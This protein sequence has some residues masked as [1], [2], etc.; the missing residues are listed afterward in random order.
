MIS[1]ISTYFNP[2]CLTLD[3][4]YTEWLCWPKGRQPKNACHVASYGSKTCV[5]KQESKLS[6]WPS[7]TGQIIQVSHQ[8]NAWFDLNFGQSTSINRR[9][10]IASKTSLDHPCSFAMQTSKL[11]M[12]GLPI[13]LDGKKSSDIAESNL[14]S[15]YNMLIWSNMLIIKIYQDHHL[16][17]T[18]GIHGVRNRLLPQNSPLTNSRLDTSNPRVHSENPICCSQKPRK[19]MMNHRYLGYP[20]EE[21]INV[22]PFAAQ[23]SLAWFV[24]GRAP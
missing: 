13:I 14:W 10:W 20:H 17:K 15:T 7:W 16:W 9:G 18:P 1:I 22:P 21:H 4:P 3:K 8:H 19:K 24:Q 6:P 12:T 23:Q 11:P 5:N 2:I